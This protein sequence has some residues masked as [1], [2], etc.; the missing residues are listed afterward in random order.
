MTVISVPLRFSRLQLVIELGAIGKAG[1]DVVPCQVDDLGLGAPPLG[2]VFHDRQPAAARHRLARQ[3]QQAAV[4]Q[5][6]D[7]LRIGRQRG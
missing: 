6:V 2:D 5:F 7:P 3:Q 4:R 1:Q